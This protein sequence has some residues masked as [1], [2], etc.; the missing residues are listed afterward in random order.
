MSCPRSRRLAPPTPGHNP[1]APT[2]PSSA[3]CA[4]PSSGC[5]DFVDPQCQSLPISCF[6]HLAQAWATWPMQ[7]LKPPEG[8]WRGAE[9]GG[10]GVLGRQ[11]R[12]PG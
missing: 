1:G 3:P 4:W 11:S 5:R 9:G 10:E 7:E 8:L 12:V 2:V 6:A